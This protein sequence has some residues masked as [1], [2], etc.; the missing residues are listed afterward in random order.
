MQQNFLFLHH[1][2]EVSGKYIFSA[3]RIQN[4]NL[5]RQSLKRMRFWGKP[6]KFFS[7]HCSFKKNIWI[8]YRE[9]TVSVPLSRSS[10]SALLNSTTGL[11]TNTRLYHGSSSSSTGSLK[12][13]SHEIFGVFY[14]LYSTR[15]HL[16]PLRFHCVGGCWDQTHECCDYGIDCHTLLDKFHPLIPSISTCT[17]IKWV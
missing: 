3:F 17:Y 8:S 14:V 6:K 1:H 2:R 5:G 9:S 4:Q 11:Y 12:G 15:F 10:P 13:R 16:P 7:L